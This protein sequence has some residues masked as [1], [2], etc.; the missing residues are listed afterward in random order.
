MEENIEIRVD[1]L[2]REWTKRDIKNEV[3]K[4]KKEGKEL[5]SISIVKDDPG[6]YAAI[7]RHFDSFDEAI[8][9]A[10]YNPIKIRKKFR[11]KS[12]E[13]IINC[14]KEYYNAG[15]RLE[16]KWI[17]CKENKDKRLKSL[18]WAASWRFGGWRNAL[19]KCGINPEAYVKHKERWSKEKIKEKI[20]ELYE[21]GEPLNANYILKKS[22]SLYKAGRIYFGSWKNAIESAGFDYSKISKEKP[23][24][25]EEEIIKEIKKLAKSNHSLNM[26]SVKKSSDANIRRLYNRA[27]QKFG[28]WKNA[29]QK[30]GIDYEKIRKV[31]KPYT[32]EELIEIIK[33]LAA[34]GVS[35]KASDIGRDREN[36]KYYIAAQRRFHNWKEFLKKA[37]IDA[38]YLEKTYWENGEN[39]IKQLKENFKDGIASQVSVKYPKLYKAAIKYF[40]GIKEACKKAGLI[41]SKDGRITKEMLSEENLKILQECNAKWIKVIGAIVNLRAKASGLKSN[42]DELISVGFSVFNEKI[43]EKP[44]EKDLRDFLLKPI[45]MAMIEKIKERNKLNKPTHIEDLSNIRVRDIEDR[46]DLGKSLKVASIDDLAD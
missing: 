40:G 46:L 3:K 31:R 36:R 30:A 24:I 9:Y 15:A 43:T 33:N 37:G 4:R 23:R 21:N 27:C 14:I 34:K 42:L 6:L 22:M 17:R 2:Y 45:G 18:Y 39:V 20:L 26:V 32:N 25:K 28:S 29:I 13:E 11:Y 8:K 44:P 38:P 5:N 10:G 1:K 16:S 7:L 12:E 35:L 19:I 41:Y